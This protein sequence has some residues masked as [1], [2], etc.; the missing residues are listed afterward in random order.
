MKIEFVP[1]KWPTRAAGDQTKKPIS[2]G[3]E[4]GAQITSF[5]F[6]NELNRG[7]AS[8]CFC[9]VVAQ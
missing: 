9:R 1:P 2:G 6:T 5:N 8:S 4:I 7:G 3:S